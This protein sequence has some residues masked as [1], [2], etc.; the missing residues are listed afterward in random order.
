MN[1][2]LPKGKI[3]HITVTASSIKNYTVNNSCPRDCITCF[4]CAEIGHWKSEC[5]LYKTRLCWHNKMGK[6]TDPACPF[7]HNESELRTPWKPK[8]I[9]VIKREGKLITLGCNSTLHTFRQ[10]PYNQYIQD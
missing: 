4:R 10:C 1:T 9:R 7:A 6:C 3:I 2:I 5:M 8:C